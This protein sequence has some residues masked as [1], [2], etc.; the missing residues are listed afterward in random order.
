[1]MFGKESECCLKRHAGL[2]YCQSLLW[3]AGEEKSSRQ[4]V[5]RF[6]VCTRGSVAMY[7]ELSYNIRRAIGEGYNR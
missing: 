5:E 4:R 7:G 3:V 6:C 1:M 2:C